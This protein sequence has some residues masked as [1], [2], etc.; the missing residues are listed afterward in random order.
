MQAEGGLVPSAPADAKDGVS[1]GRSLVLGY[2]TL[3][4]IV[5][6]DIEEPIPTCPIILK[7]D[8]RSQLH[9]LFF[10]KLIAQARIQLIGN[11]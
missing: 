5:A 7:S 11:I 9:Q 2:C 6:L 3:I 8:L 10:G 4:K 1:S